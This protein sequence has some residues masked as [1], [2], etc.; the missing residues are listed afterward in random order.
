MVGSDE[1]VIVRCDA[2][3]IL[4]VHIK[5]PVAVSDA[6][7]EQECRIGV[8]WARFDQTENDLPEVDFPIV[9]VMQFKTFNVGLPLLCVFEEL[10]EVWSNRI[11]PSVLNLVVCAVCEGKSCKVVDC[12]SEDDLI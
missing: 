11:A 1:W 5:L 2:L 8:S 12:C 10:I 4:I 3:S 9:I 6:V 7:A